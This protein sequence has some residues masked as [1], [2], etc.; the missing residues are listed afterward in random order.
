[1]ESEEDRIIAEVLADQSPYAAPGVAINTVH[2]RFQIRLRQKQ[3]EQQDAL[4]ALQIQML[5]K[6][7]ASTPPN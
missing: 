4:L 5:K 7:T 2:S 3:R 6:Q 1:M